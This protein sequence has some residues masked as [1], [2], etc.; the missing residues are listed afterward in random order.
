VELR[1]VEQLGEHLGNL[2][3]HDARA[4]VLHRHQEPPL[5]RLP[6]LHRDLRQDA[7][8]F[9]GVQ[10]V[11]DRFL[12]R[13]HDRLAR[14]VEPQ[15]MPVLQEEFRNGNLPLLLGHAFG[16]FLR[17]AF[18]RHRSLPFP[19]KSARIIP[20]PIP[21]RNPSLAPLFKRARLGYLPRMTI[22]CPI[23]TA[24]YDAITLAHG[25]GGTLTA[26]LIHDIFL[27]AFGAHAPSPH[28]ATPVALGGARLALTTDSYVVQPLFFPGGDIGSL[29]VN[30]TVNDLLMAGAKPVALTAGFILE[31]GLPI[32]T[33][34]RVVDSMRAAAEA[35]G[36]AIVAGDTKVI[37]R[38]RGDGLYVN[39][40]G[41]GEILTPEPLAPGRIRAGDVILLT[42]DIARHGIAVMARRHQLTFEPPVASDC[43]SLHGPILELFANGPVPHCARDLTRGGLGGA[44]CELAAAAGF[45]FQIDEA[46]LPVAKP[47]RAACE[48][49]GFDPLFVANEGC[50]A[51]F[52]APEE[53]APALAVLQRHPVSAQARVI[54]T[55]AARRGRL[56]PHRPRH[57][58]PPHARPPANSCRASADLIHPG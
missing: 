34:R 15:Q 16:R 13:R 52:I 39:T 2:R 4:V 42:G 31:E 3:A 47:V 58:P 12:H 10:R 24:R 37:E 48:L 32:D 25:G 8:L 11:V 22:S 30:G 5:G 28:D 23:P 33:L 41:V 27:P 40:S 50:A 45:A 38:A 44:L 35:A 17:H 57:R 43:A 21:S 49:L 14:T 26:A 29:A 9:A 1:A 7:R 36:V 18:L 20:L 53:A 51:L 46:E 56:R 6:Q 19:S 54:G 55:V